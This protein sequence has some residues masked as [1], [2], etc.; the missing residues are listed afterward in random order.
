MSWTISESP[1]ELKEKCFGQRIDCTPTTASIGNGTAQAVQDYV[2][3]MQKVVDYYA[4]PTGDLRVTFF[5][6]P[7][8]C[9]PMFARLGCGP[10]ERTPSVWVASLNKMLAFFATHGVNPT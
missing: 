3:T 6:R 2:D 7:V 10:R 5:G 4:A 1:T 8:E 9:Q